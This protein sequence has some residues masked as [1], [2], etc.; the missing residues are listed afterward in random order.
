M[1][2][3]A[4]DL[5]SRRI[6]LAICSPEETVVVGAGVIER[7]PGDDALPAVAQAARER[8]AEAFVVGHPINMD[9]TRGNKAAEA[10]EFA[11]RLRKAVGVPVEMWDERLSSHAAEE[12]LREVKM[13]RG[14]KRIHVNQVAAQV[15]LEGYL[16][17]RRTRGMSP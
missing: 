9:G 7:R 4:V 13:K 12:R 11:E 16:D 14:Q 6:G 5:G 15:I 3:L 1:R 2:I 8:D 17:D 10:E